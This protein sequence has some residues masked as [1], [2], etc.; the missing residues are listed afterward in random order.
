MKVLAIAFVYNEMPFIERAIDYYKHQGCDLYVIDNMSTDGTWEWLQE[1]N[2]PSHQF[3]TLNSFQLEWL[4]EEMIKTIHKIKPDWFLWF[5][6]D[7]FHV[8]SSTIKETIEE[9]ECLDYNQIVSDCYCVKNTGEE[10]ALPLYEHY[11]Y[12]SINK[13]V[14]LCSKYSNELSILADRITIPYPEKAEM[15]VILEYGGCKPVEY[16]EAKLKRR[17]KAWKMGTPKGH[18]THYLEGKKKNWIYEK[19]GL[20][21]IWQDE[22][23]IKYVHKLRLDNE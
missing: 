16:Q 11:K 9:V 22:N 3:N 10:Y 6:P 21:D 1:N 14:L 13:R 4:Q 7:L 18:G 8:F 5:A 19:E 20:I 17:Q 12:A 2:I 15:G 23:I